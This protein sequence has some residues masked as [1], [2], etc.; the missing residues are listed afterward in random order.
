MDAMTRGLT[1]L[2][3]NVKVIALATEK[4]PNV[5]GANSG[6]YE[7]VEISTSLNPIA[8]L[9]NL[10]RNRSYNLSRF[11]HSSVVSKIEKTLK[12]YEFDV[13]ILESM[14][15]C[16][17]FDTIR[18]NTDAQIILRAHNVEHKIWAELAVKALN[19]FKSWYLRRLSGQLE[20]FERSISSKLD[21]VVAITKDDGLWFKNAGA[22]RIH[23]LPFSMEFSNQSSPNTFDHVFH[24]GSMDWLPN[25]EGVNWM[26]DEVWPLVRKES[27]E[28]RLVIAGRSMPTELKSDSSMGVE[29]VGEVESAA[30]FLDRPGIA[31]VPILSG[32]G[33]RIKAVEAMA[34][35]L[36]VVGTELGLA[37]LDLENGTHALIANTPNDFARAILDLLSDSGKAS[38]IAK[39]GST[40][41]QQKFDTTLIFNDL[42][43]FIKNID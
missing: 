26:L 35:G 12:S 15:A 21:G 29:V 32:S 14:Y 10:F 9:F 16:V 25:I 37:G 43:C 42:I 8:A 20:N 5:E 3:H 22:S 18:K 33:M 13:V 1:S 6:N 41:V 24:F 4:H 19:P 11:Y 28:A 2:G 39:N 34:A 17:Y 38:A 40:H 7:Y 30:E 36:P 23:T 31:S 27:S